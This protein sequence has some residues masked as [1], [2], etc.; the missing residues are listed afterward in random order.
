LQ[1]VDFLSLN[2][3]ALSVYFP[4]HPFHIAQLEKQEIFNWNQIKIE[5]LI[6]EEFLIFKSILKTSQTSVGAVILLLLEGNVTHQHQQRVL[7]LLMP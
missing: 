4:T 5:K 2:N 1:L 3:L 7:L 6:A